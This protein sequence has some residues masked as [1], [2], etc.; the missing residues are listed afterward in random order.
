M[1][2]TTTHRPVVATLTTIF[3][4]LSQIEADTFTH[5]EADPAIDALGQLLLIASEREAT[6]ATLATGLD[7]LRDSLWS[8]TAA[9]DAAEAHDQTRYTVCAALWHAVGAG[10][11]ACRSTDAA[12]RSGLITIAAASVAEALY[13]ASLAA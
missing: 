5:G 7:H 10:A 6:E 1:H 8:L 13:A 9:A 3:G 4:T 12:R 11:N 2:P